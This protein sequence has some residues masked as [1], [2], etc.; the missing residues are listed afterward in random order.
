LRTSRKRAADEAGFTSQGTGTEDREPIML[1]PVS[2]LYRLGSRQLTYNS[3]G[4]HRSQS[5]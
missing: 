1:T 4:R 2:L 5:G 3:A